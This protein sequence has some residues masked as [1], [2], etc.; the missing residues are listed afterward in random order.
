MLG[1]HC[2]ATDD[3]AVSLGLGDGVREV[4]RQSVER[5]DGHGLLGLRGEETV[6][7]ARLIAFADVVDVYQRAAGAGAAVAVA[8]ERSGTQFDPALV[9]LLGEEAGPILGDLDSASSWDTVISAEPALARSITDAELGGALEAVADF[10]DLK[11]PH[12][13]GHSRTVADLAGL[14]A[15]AAGLPAA[16]ATLVRR[17]GLVHDLGRLGR[18]P[19]PSR[20]SSRTCST[21][22]PVGCASAWTTAP[23][24]SSVPAMS[25]RSP[26]AMTPRW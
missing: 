19:A 22:S 11:S 23:R 12:T 20:A 5:W 16:E 21:C 14:A 6:L 1:N 26:L 2:L 9:E 15:S 25:R 8:R 7:P 10:V 17:A 24:P 18:L 4:L 13:L 3:L